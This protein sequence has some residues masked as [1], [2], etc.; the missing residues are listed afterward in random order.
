MS[1]CSY[2]LFS[3]SLWVL[4]ILWVRMERGTSPDGTASLVD[5]G[6]GGWGGRESVGE[7][8]SGDVV[9]KCGGWDG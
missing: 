1:L 7:W 9:R 2:S 3:H 5:P 8:G 6:S 4:N